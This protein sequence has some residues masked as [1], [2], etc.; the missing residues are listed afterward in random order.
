M[1]PPQDN[2]MCRSANLI[3]AQLVKKVKME[4]KLDNVISTEK[5]MIRLLEFY[6]MCRDLYITAKQYYERIIA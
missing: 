2:I 3:A 6:V 1:W 5:I 4:E